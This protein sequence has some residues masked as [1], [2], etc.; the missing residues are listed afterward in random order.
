MDR[1]ME[2]MRLLCGD[3]LYWRQRSQQASIAGYDVAAAKMLAVAQQ[4]EEKIGD[5]I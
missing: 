4:V 2:I 5:R 3:L 1:D